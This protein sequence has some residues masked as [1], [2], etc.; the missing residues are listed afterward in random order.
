MRRT[1]LLAI[2]VL[3]I[4]Y[5]VMS[6]TSPEVIEIVAQQEPAA[7]DTLAEDVSNEELKLYIDVYSAMQQ[8]HSLTVEDALQGHN[9]TIEE[10]RNIERRVQSKTRLVEK[11]RT[12]LVEQARRRSAFSEPLVPAKPDTPKKTDKKTAPKQ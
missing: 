8:D 3:L 4:A 7:D 10:F 9:V 5:S 6:R 1:I 11:V 12:A 2:P